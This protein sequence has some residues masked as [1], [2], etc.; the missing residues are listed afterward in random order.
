MSGKVRDTTP[1]IKPF[2]K[3]NDLLFSVKAEDCIDYLNEGK[4]LEDD[5]S[6]KVDVTKTIRFGSKVNEGIRASSLIH[7]DKK[8]TIL[9]YNEEKKETVYK[10][11][12]LGKSSKHFDFVK[13]HPRGQ[14]TFGI[15]NVKLENAK[16]LIYPL[17]FYEKV[18]KEENKEEIYKCSHQ[19]WGPGEKV[20]RRYE[21]D[22]TLVKN[23]NEFRFGYAEDAEKDVVKKTIFN[24]YRPPTSKELYFDEKLPDEESLKKKENIYGVK[25]RSDD[26]GAVEC[27]RGY[28]Y[29]LDKNVT[30]LDRTMRAPVPEQLKNT[31]F[32][33]V[34]VK[35]EPTT[36][37]IVSNEREYVE[38]EDPMS[39]EELQSIVGDL[40]DEEGLDFEYVYQLAI[41]FYKTDKLS[42]NSLVD[43]IN[44]LT[45]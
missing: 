20:N 30:F 32:G 4:L 28:N 6:D 27:I 42:V 44:K 15:K 12:P 16:D 10:R 1:Y 40:V 35:K 5:R 33:V 3:P 37:Q 14:Q 11:Q 34:T 22:K 24:Y 36:K 29:G 21:W 18:K 25:S 38:R 43:I 45:L 7:S 31:T 17:E 39:K 13:N 23:P 26:W 9:N 8:S 2:G 19:E 41:D